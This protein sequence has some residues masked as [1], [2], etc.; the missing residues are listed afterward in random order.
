MAS[1]RVPKTSIMVC[2]EKLLKTQKRE[3]GYLMYLK[4]PNRRNVTIYLMD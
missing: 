1:G 4:N 3:L 2:I